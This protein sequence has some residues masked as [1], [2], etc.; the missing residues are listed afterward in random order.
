MKC[1]HLP[2]ISVLLMLKKSW[3]SWRFIWDQK[4]V[5]KLLIF[6]RVNLIKLDTILI[7]GGECLNRFMI[8][9]Q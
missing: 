8:N 4:N 7:L 3:S 2:K 5:F 6:G 9:V 1:K